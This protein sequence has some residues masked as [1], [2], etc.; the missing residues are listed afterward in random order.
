MTNTTASV[1]TDVQRAAAV[2]ERA[3]WAIAVAGGDDDVDHPRA[4]A[5]LQQQA[6]YWEDLGRLFVSMGAGDAAAAVC[7]GIADQ[8]TD[9]VD[10]CEESM[11]E[12]ISE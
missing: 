6:R 9:A 4:Q 7:A 12:P 10:V 8:C 3:E 2:R 5:A 1:A 11:H